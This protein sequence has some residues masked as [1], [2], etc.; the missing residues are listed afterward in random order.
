VDTKRTERSL[1]LQKTFYFLL[2]IVIIC[3]LFQRWYS[4]GEDVYKHIEPA[5]RTYPIMGTWAQ[6]TLYGDKTKVD[7]AQ[8]K[9]YNAFVEINKTCS[10]FN[11]EDELAK[12]NSSA[13][14]HPFKCSD[15]LW[16]VLMLS[17]KYYKESNGAFDITVTPLM[18]LWGFYAKQDKTPTRLQVQEALKKVGFNKLIFNDQAHTVRFSVEGMELD[19]GGIAKGFAL[20]YAYDKIKSTGINEGV[21]NLGGNILCLPD[22]P[23]DKKYYVLAIRNPLDKEKTMNGSL[24]LVNEA[25]STSGDYEQYIV[26][27]GKRYSHIINPKTGYPIADMISVTAIAPTGVASDALSTSVF[28][29]GLDFAKRIHDK[30]SK[31]QFFI[32]T[33]EH[34][35]PYSIKTHKIGNAWNSIKL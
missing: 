3:I 29:N 5:T 12:L 33:G 4:T 15:T 22:G 34:E 9:I 31:I 24:E 1:L 6:V 30:N 27:D 21:I 2:V 18:K 13:Y 20:D 25:L 7:I 8:D 23:L 32:V 16:Q 14:Y 11:S 35:D 10:R 19:L 28:L 17:Q 26:F